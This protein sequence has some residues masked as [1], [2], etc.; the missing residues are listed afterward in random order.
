M[1]SNL[2]IATLLAAAIGLT[3]PALAGH[4]EGD[5]DD[6]DAELIAEPQTWRLV[7][8]YEV[9]IEDARPGDAFDLVFHISENGYVLPDAQGRPYQIV[10]PLDQPTE[11]D[12]DE[13]TFES[14]FSVQIGYNSF[15]DPDHLRL[16]ARLIPRGY[17]HPLD[18]E[19]TGIDCDD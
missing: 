1:R 10:I 17:N 16:H 9:E 18:K 11:I 19:S 12:D 4:L 5:L 13:M 14:R 2:T 8:E 15:Q 7:V 6:L 3:S